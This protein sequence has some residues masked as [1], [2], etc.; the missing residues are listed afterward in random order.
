VDHVRQGEPDDREAVVVTVTAAFA[1]DPAWSFL[2][3]DAYD[4]LAPEFAGALFDTRV[5]SE[6]VWVTSDLAAVA[7]WEQMGG[8]RPPAVGSEQIWKGF[9]A[10]AGESAWTRLT[11]YERAVDV[12]RPT[13]P[14]WYL[15]VLA[16]RPDRL[17]EGLATAV[18]TPV[19][20]RADREGLDCCLETSTAA[21]LR[22]YE[23]RGFI[24]TTAVHIMSGP[25]TWWLRRAPQGP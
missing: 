7:M 19:L 2:L 23:G 1:N 13:S 25:P 12:A 11:E 14:Y 20:E 21:N 10:A 15:G 17:R 6:G 5:N 24:D 18:M 16:T 9:R 4:R 3:E 22:F 8:D